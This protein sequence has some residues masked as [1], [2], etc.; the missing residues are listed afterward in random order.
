MIV[1]S[2]RDT[3]QWR[4][5]RGENRGRGLTIIETAMDHLD[6]NRAADGTEIVMKRQLAPK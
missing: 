3:G 5:P 2:I 1:I 6:I 4:A